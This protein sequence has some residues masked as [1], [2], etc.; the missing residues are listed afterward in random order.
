[1][2]LSQLQT[3]ST[4][5]ESDSAW[6]QTVACGALDVIAQCSLMSAFHTQPVSSAFQLSDLLSAAATR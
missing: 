6:P 1:M 5:P 4:V 3:H 2:E